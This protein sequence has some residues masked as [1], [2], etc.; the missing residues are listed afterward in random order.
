MPLVVVKDVDA[1]LDFYQRAFGFTKRM[2][3]PGP[4]GRSMH[5]EVGWQDAIIMLSPEQPERSPARAPAASGVPSP[6]GLYIYVEDVD[7]LFA[8]ATAAG[9]KAE[10]PPQD[11]FWGDRMCRVTDPDGHTWGFATN[12][13]DFDPSKV[14]H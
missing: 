4:D 3:L 13:A 11:M 8:R 7:A 6:V 2:T 9:A 12:I 10:M 5:G 14:P 1:A